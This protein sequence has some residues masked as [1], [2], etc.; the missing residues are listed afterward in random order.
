MNFK[1]LVFCLLSLQ[2]VFFVNSVPQKRVRQFENLMNAKNDKKNTDSQKYVSADSAVMN[3][4]SRAMNKV[5]I[6]KKQQMKNVEPSK[7][8]YV[9][10]GCSDKNLA[11][12]LFR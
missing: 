3:N 7:D 1:G 10:T 12:D 8:V 6:R 9:T 11:Y 5:E 2:S 4:I